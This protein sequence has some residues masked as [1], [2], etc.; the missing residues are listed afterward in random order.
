MKISEDK[1][2]EL[3]NQFDYSSK[4]YLTDFEYQALCYSQ[5][6]RPENLGE[7]VTFNELSQTFN[8]YNFNAHSDSEEDSSDPKRKKSESLNPTKKLFL[9]LSDGSDFITVE[10]LSKMLSKIN[11]SDIARTCIDEISET[12]KISYKQFHKMFHNQL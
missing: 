5:M 1:L 10:S 7:K 8:S 9:A 11:M 12:G 3:F 2:R 6:V 4:N